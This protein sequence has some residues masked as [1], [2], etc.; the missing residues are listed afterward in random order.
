MS[1]FVLVHCGWHGSWCWDA[2]IPQLERAGHEVHAPDL[3]GHGEDRTPVSEVSL[4]SYANRV[5]QVLDENSEP[6][7]LVGHS[8]GGVVI[9]EVA[10]R[11][12]EK[13]DV[14]VYL[15]A[16]LLPRG[17]NVLDAAQNDTESMLR[18]NIQMD[19]ERGMLTVKEDELQDIFYHDC[20]EDVVERAR[21]LVQ[22][23]PVAPLATPVEVT[24]DRFGSVRRSY[25][26][27]HLDRATSPLLQ[28]KMYIDLP[29]QKLA[30]MN[31]S[32]FPMLSAPEE[33]AEHLDS[34]ATPRT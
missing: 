7:V 17:T 27:C 10:E 16:F 28:T 34:L 24:E 1:T 32:H 23:E 31:A 8:S 11:R 5:C 25:I 4:A 21:R 14:L 29:C 2:I 9:S 13:T 26:T 3:P 30:S 12:P 20:S 19:E 6:V 33:L 22:P 18:P 15:T